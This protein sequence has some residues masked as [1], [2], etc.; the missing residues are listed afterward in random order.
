MQNVRTSTRL[1]ENLRIAVH[2]LVSCDALELSIDILLQHNND[3]R[4]I[5]NRELNAMNKKHHRK[6]IVR[7]RW[8]LVLSA[9]LLVVVLL[10]A[11]P[12][13]G[14]NAAESTVQDE[15]QRV[16]DAVRAS[17]T[18]QFTADIVQTTIP[19]PLPENIGRS[20][21]QQAFHLEGST[22]VP[23]QTFRLT[24]WLQGGSVLDTNSGLQIKLEDGQT[25]AR[26]GD[27]AWQ[28][29]SD[30][31][32]GIAP[33]GDFMSYLVAIQD[34]VKHDPETRHGI[35]FTRYTF[36]L[37]G[38]V[39]AAFVRDQMQASLAQQGKLPAGAQLDLPSQYRDMTGE[40]ELWVS[41]DG[42]PLRQ[43]INM[44]F[45]PDSDF[46]TEALSTINFSDFAPLPPAFRL[47]LT[48]AGIVNTAEAAL[49]AMRSR[50]PQP[51]S[52]RAG[53]GAGLRLPSACLRLP[54][55]EARQ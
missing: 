35:S 34:V 53:A 22:N 28:E 26:Q 10:I 27:Q 15:V 5:A 13:L 18:Y 37:D 36:E 39:Y 46:K 4:K 52:G 38:P 47:D 7:R 44:R 2:H 41:A 32:G 20:S 29:T 3:T 45:P 14:L 48:A 49:D 30:L 31:T 21:K 9:G 50:P 51:G 17:G 55:L 16:W 24:M 19:L 42:L 43:I 12:P 11:L 40:G 23:Q 1:V 6:Q 8:A 54:T 33:F 25:Y